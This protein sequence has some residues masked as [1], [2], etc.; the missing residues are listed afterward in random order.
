MPIGGVA[1]GRVSPAA[2]TAGLFTFI[3]L[4]LAIKNLF[5]RYMSTSFGPET[6]VT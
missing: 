3:G 5:E 4:K 2:C 6:P 1:S